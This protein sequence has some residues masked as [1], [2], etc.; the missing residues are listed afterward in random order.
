MILYQVF[1]Y[2][3]AVSLGDCSKLDMWS[4]NSLIASTTR[5]KKTAA[6]HFSDSNIDR[7][8]DKDLSSKRFLTESCTQLQ[9]LNSVQLNQFT[10]L[11]TPNEGLQ[12][13]ETFEFKREVGETW[14]PP[15]LI[16]ASSSAACR[17]SLHTV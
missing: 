12:L 9:T 8:C 14:C 15:C 2:Q 17:V 4:Q 13:L 7:Y 10:A 1:P 6:G 11:G 3:G 16:S 5:G